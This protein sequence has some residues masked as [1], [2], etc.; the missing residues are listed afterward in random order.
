MSD[1]AAKIPPSRRL[2]VG[3]NA[4]LKRIWKDMRAERGR[5]QADYL[6][7]STSRTER[8]VGLAL[9]AGVVA[10]ERDADGVLMAFQFDAD[11]AMLA[12]VQEY[13]DTSRIRSQ[14]KSRAHRCMI[15]LSIA[16]D[17]EWNLELTEYGRYI[18]AAAAEK[19]S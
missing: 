17:D 5:M 6:V 2:G 14:A 16:V 11:R 4:G 13:P 7:Q 10:H 9:R 1:Q 8:N 18:A 3:K 19:T 12:V 15:A